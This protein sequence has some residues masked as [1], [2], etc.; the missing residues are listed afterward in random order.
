MKG[1]IL[2]AGNG[3]RL[4]PFTR[5][6]PKVL[7][8][9]ANK[10]IVQYGIEKLARLGIEEIG[11]VIQPAHK[12]L[13][14][15]QVGRG[16]KW[17]VAIQY[18]YQY[19]PD[20]IADA[21]K[22]AADFIGDEPCMLLLGDNLIADSLE[23]LRDSIARG[24]CDAALLLGQVSNPG[25]YGIAELEGDR[26]V[27]LEEKPAIPKSNTAILGA[28]AF[29]PGLLEAVRAIEPSA[30]GEYEMTD[31]LQ[32]ML[33]RDRRIAYRL[34][35]GEHSDVGRPERWL[36]AN[37][38]MLDAIASVN[39]D[40]ARWREA[41]C[42]I[43]GPVAIDDTAELENCAIGPYVAIG[44]YARLA[45][46]RV[47]DSILLGGVGLMNESVAQAIVSPRHAYNHPRMEG[48]R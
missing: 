48:S 4:H 37:R 34:T 27:G 38:W 36:A 17:G 46:C 6:T 42:T 11:I 9:V 35:K 28:Y 18:L 43:V 47:R 45:N 16:A 23:S 40:D 15:Q 44:P 10:P 33:R 30:R 31:A 2:G 5:V 39:A 14:L 3:T 1:L 19:R 7:L 21:V 26:I 24:D 12:S 22:L 25:D 8:P 13:F 32:W 20:G 41:G 29:G